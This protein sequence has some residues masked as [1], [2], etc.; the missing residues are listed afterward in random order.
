MIATEMYIIYLENNKIDDVNEYLNSE[1]II[2]IFNIYQSKINIIIKS[3]ENNKY[4][5]DKKNFNSK[6]K[7][8][9]ELS[10]KYISGPS[11]FNK[12]IEKLKKNINF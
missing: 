2:K 7:F 3:I 12:E 5:Y 4:S 11:D 8:Y 9:D 1:E 6:R 10:K